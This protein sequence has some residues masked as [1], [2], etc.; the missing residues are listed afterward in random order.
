[1]GYGRKKKVSKVKEF[2]FCVFDKEK[3][4]VVEGMVCCAVLP[5]QLS[6]SLYSSLFFL[7]L[8]IDDASGL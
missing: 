1:M 8:S 6:L 2:S 7:V 3:G 5:T 4:T